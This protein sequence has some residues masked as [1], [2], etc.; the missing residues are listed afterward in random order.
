VAA[1]LY[2]VIGNDVNAG[3][4]RQALFAKMEDEMELALVAIFKDESREARR[5]KAVQPLVAQPYPARIPEPAKESIEPELELLY[6]DHGG[7]GA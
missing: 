6:Q 5:A 4:V 2:K 1:E 7:A 3:D